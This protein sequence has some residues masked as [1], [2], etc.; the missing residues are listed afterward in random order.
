MMHSQYNARSDLR[1]SCSSARPWHRKTLASTPATPSWSAG[2]RKN[3][4]PDTPLA[5]YCKKNKR[6]LDRLARNVA[7]IANLMESGADFV[8]VDMPQATRLTI[9]ILA[10]VAEHE[11][12]MISKRTRA[13]L[14][15]AKRRGT[16]LGNPRIEEARAKA[17]SAHRAHRPAPEVAKLMT[18]WRQQG[19]RLRE[20]ASSLNRL[21]IRPPRG[22]AWY[23][24]SVRNQLMTAH[25]LQPSLQRTTA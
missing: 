6:R 21:N 1:A 12:E 15:E 5:G 9:H 13:A 17:I 3:F 10:A 20:I 4:L 25:A 2:H 16:K 14:A 22:R 11:R 18:D 7:F 8:A 23:A 24:S 19:K